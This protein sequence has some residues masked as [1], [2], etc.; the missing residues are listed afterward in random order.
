MA[1]QGSGR[2]ARRR[3]PDG[4][5]SRRLRELGGIRPVCAGAF[6]EMSDF[7]TT[8][9]KAAADVGA[10]LKWRKMRCDDENHCRAIL[11]PMLKRHIGMAALLGNARCAIARLGV[12]DAP[13]GVF[14]QRTRAPAHLRQ[15]RDSALDHFGMRRVA[16]VT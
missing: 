9:V 14:S 13:A 3:G 4:P 11:V 8:L 15:R 2:G 5:I 1:G 6:G 16:R 10:E 7:V 12:F